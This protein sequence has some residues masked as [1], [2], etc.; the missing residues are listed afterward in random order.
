V[1]GPEVQA[2][3]RDM[4]DNDVPMTSTLVVY[5]ISVA[6]RPPIE[7]RVFDILAPEI[8]AEVRRSPKTGGP[9]GAPSTRRSTRRRSSTSGRSSRP[10]GCS[11]GRRPDRVRRRAPGFGDQRNYEL[12]LEAGFTPVQVV[13]IMSANG[14]KVLGIDGEVGTVEA[15]KVADL[16]VIE[17]DI[18][19]RGISAT[20]TSSS[21][22]GSG[23]TPGR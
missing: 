5:E 14:A 17:G 20:R 11:G 21:G 15:G 3:F 7:E 22:T 16:V 12:L 1:N 4:I 18:E 10:A 23:G 6:D 9:A 8:A 19:A 13:Q 2:T